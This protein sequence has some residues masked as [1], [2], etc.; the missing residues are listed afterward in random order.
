MTVRRITKVTDDQPPSL[1]I[2]E[3]LASV[4]GMSVLEMEPL[5]M[6]ID[7]DALDTI[8]EREEENVEVSF[9]Y[10]GYEVTATPVEIAV[11]DCHRE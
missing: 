10:N 3:E 6:T 4:T 1:Q 7:T 2:A 8:L 9:Q 11:Q 5:Q